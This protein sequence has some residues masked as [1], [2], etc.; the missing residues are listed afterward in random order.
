M[1]P[2]FPKNDVL[3]YL[4]IRGSYGEVGNDRSVATGFCTGPRPTPRLT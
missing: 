1:K 3:T 4:K 2:F